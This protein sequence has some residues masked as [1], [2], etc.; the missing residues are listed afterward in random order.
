MVKEPDPEPFLSCGGFLT[1]GEAAEGVLTIFCE[2]GAAVITVRTWVGAGLSAGVGCDTGG[3]ASGYWVQAENR[4]VTRDKHNKQWM[5]FN[6]I[7]LSV[8]SSFL[9]EG[10]GLNISRRMRF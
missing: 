9:N 8:V 6:D 1:F 3:C 5:V 4:V 7:F 2:T 10:V